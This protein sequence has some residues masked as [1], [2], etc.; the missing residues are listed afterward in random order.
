MLNQHRISWNSGFTCTKL[1]H[2][3]ITDFYIFNEFIKSI[4][5]SVYLK[6]SIN[7]PQPRV[8]GH[9]FL[10]FSLKLIESDTRIRLV[11]NVSKL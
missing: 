7:I 10:S 6:L 3:C 4:A 9:V 1:L 11:M 2:I 8:L 5:K